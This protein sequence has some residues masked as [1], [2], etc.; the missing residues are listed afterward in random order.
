MISKLKFFPI[1]IAC[2]S[3]FAFSSTFSSKWTIKNNLNQSI[4]LTCKNLK[5]NGLNILF[6]NKLIPHNNSVIYD[7]GDNYYNDGLGLNPGNWQCKAQTL[8]EKSSPTDFM[9]FST[10]WGENMIL[11][12]DKYDEK[13]VLIKKSKENLLNN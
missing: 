9:S 11:I 1:I 7:W 5:E 12:I 8:E 3:V 13:I 10:D 4:N 6:E 2:S